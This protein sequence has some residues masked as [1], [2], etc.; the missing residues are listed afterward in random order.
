MPAYKTPGVYV[1]ESPSLPPTVV[2]VPVAIPVFIGYTE[3]AT[4]AQGV[5][6]TKTMTRITSL[7]EYE[8]L[9]GRAP[10]QVANITVDQ[11]SGVNPGFE[12][13]WTD[14]PPRP[15]D[16]LY[17]TLQLYFANGGGPCWIYSID[18]HGTP[19]RKE[20]FTNAITIIEDWDEP[21]LLLF[22][23]ATR[24]SDED[25]GFV[26]SFA[27]SSCARQRNRF[28]IADV[29]RA[30]AEGTTP[31]LVTRNFRNHVAGT[32]EQ[33]GYGAAYFPYVQTLV[34][35]R[36]DDESVHLTAFTKN[37]VSIAVP[38]VHHAIRA[39][40]DAACVTL[41]ASGGIAG[42]HAQ[43][44]R[45]RDVWKAP[46]GMPLAL[47]LRPAIGVTDEQ[48]STL[49]VDVETGK[50]V[51]CLRAFSGRGTLVWGAR[52][53]AG[54][55]NEWRYINVRRLASFIEASV[56][57][58]VHAFAFEPNTASTWTRVRA[59]IA[60]FLTR[61]WQDGA[62]TG[63]KPDEAFHVDVGLGTTMT[64]QDV[65]DGILIVEVRIAVIRPA[66]FIVLRLRQQMLNAY[67]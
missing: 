30:E 15:T 28:T 5:S 53:L 50:S 33:L 32:I 17:Y 43:M 45:T 11:R 62:L 13:R 24:L 10:V 41:P 48:Q 29:P 12:V 47:V 1:E 55:D 38:A 54:N 2:P 64:A 42:I 35:F 49:N 7:V 16:L 67:P 59:M 19:L 39:F 66:E 23:D 20:D 4:D 8:T 58:A 31:A 46:A 3:Y 34:P 44:G 21:T 61:L 22:P 60:D 51:N 9:F 56:G 63:M 36:F 52:T 25:Y 57:K 14:A 26:L 6:L 18:P 65:L 40:L 27:L 37:G